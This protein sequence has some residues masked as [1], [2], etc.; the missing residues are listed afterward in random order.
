ML[1]PDKNCPR[2]LNFFFKK[3]G[4]KLSS[5]HHNTVSN[6]SGKLKN[7]I[8]QGRKMIENHANKSTRSYGEFPF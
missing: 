5:Q 2:T 3:V 6:K 4:G 8:L 7:V 1:H